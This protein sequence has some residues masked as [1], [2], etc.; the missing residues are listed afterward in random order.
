MTVFIRN[1]EKTRFSQFFLP[2]YLIQTIEMSGL[3][4][5][6]QNYN[7]PAHLQFQPRSFN[8]KIGF[9][10]TPSFFEKALQDFTKKSFRKFGVKLIIIRGTLQLVIWKHIRWL[11]IDYEFRAKNR[12]KL[13]EVKTELK[14]KIF[15]HKHKVSV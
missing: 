3:R 12:T 9:S 4:A 10:P 8:N 6:F 14:T 1:A 7:R 15:T 2:K 11:V 13:V 5:C